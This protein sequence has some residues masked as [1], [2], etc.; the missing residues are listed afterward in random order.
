VVDVGSNDGTFLRC[1]LELGMKVLGVDP[2]ENI[3][4]AANASGIETLTAFF[5]EKIAESIRAERGPAKIVSANNVFAH[6]DDMGGMAD[7]VRTLLADD[8]VFVFEVSYLLD[9]VEQMLLGTIFHEHVCYHSVKPLDAFLRRH[10]MELIDVHRVGIQGGSII[11]TAQLLGGPRKIEPAVA[12]LKALEDKADLHNPATLRAFSSKI[13]TIRADVTQL[14]SQLHADGKVI[15]G[16]GAARSGTFLIY[17]FNLG[18]ILSFIVD[19]S[20]DKQGL[21]S[22]GYHIPVFPTSTLYERKPD[23]AFILAWVHSRAIIQ[24]H[25]RFLDEGGQFIICFP[26]IQVVSRDAPL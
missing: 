8:G 2:A 10:G 15:A 14:V 22:P 9:V 12:E 25:Q 24:N 1:F 6:T 18:K 7:A 5:S 11:G 13:E 20:P 17:H 23:Y 19:D 3:A 16:F 4:A 26:R 21:Y